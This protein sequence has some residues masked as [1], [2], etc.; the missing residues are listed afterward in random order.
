[1][2]LSLSH[3][4]QYPCKLRWPSAYFSTQATMGLDSS[5]PCP[6]RSPESLLL[7]CPSRTQLSQLPYSRIEFPPGYS[8]IYSTEIYG[9]RSMKNVAW[10]QQYINRTCFGLVAAPWNLFSISFEAACLVPGSQGLSPGD[11][12]AG[13]RRGRALRH[14]GQVLGGSR[15]T[16]CM[17][18]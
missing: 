2:C 17:C 6:A 4:I 18:I 3:V 16:L 1:M 11:H 5:C 8:G 12:P 13:R 15:Y 7:S 9:S 14:P 10:A